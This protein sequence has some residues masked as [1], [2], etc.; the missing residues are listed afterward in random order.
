MFGLLVGCGSGELS[1]EEICE[2]FKEMKGSEVDSKQL[3]KCVSEFTSLK[4]DDPTTYTCMRKCSGHKS[5]KAASRCQSRCFKANRPDVTVEA[6]EPLDGA[7][8]RVETSPKARV[9][10]KLELLPKA[11][12]KK[13]EPVVKKKK[14]SKKGKAKFVFSGLEKGSYTATVTVKADKKTG[15]TTKTFRVSPKALVLE[16]QDKEKDKKARTTRC[17]I[18]LTAPESTTVKMSGAV[19]LKGSGDDAVIPLL[20]RAPG[21]ERVELG[22]ETISFSKGEAK[23]SVAE[24]DLYQAMT[25]SQLSST[26][27]KGIVPLTIKAR[28]KSLR[29][30]LM[31]DVGSPLSGQLPYKGGAALKLK[32][33]GGGGSGKKAMILVEGSRVKRTV[34]DTSAPIGAL[35]HVAVMETKSRDVGGCPYHDPNT[36]SRVTVKR[37]VRNKSVVIYDRRTGKAVG[38]RSFTAKAPRCPSTLSPGRR[39]L[40][41][42]VSENDVLK[43]LRTQI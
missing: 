11:G 35:T 2:R 31:C 13:G 1:P 36:N 38:R 10:V 4:K 19:A 17:H 23:L 37:K 7:T 26:R 14:A 39:T 32:H 42:S 9:E 41:N 20:V 34:G 18:Q 33:E 28:G 25:V 40:S 12:E 21:G 3:K 8:L 6:G 16:A 30:N 5:M 29:G 22:G 24:A 15:Y 43:W 27:P